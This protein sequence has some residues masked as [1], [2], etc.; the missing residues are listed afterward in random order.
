[1][2]GKN[3]IENQMTNA[4][5]HRYYIA[6]KPW[7]NSI[8]KKLKCS[9]NGTFFLMTRAATAFICFALAS[10]SLAG[11]PVFQ[12]GM[13]SDN[14][15]KHVPLLLPMAEYLADKMQPFGYTSGKPQIF[16]DFDSARQAFQSGDL[17][18]LTCGLYEAAQM[19]SSGDASPLAI[20]WKYGVPE[21]SSL[22]IVN[23]ESEIYELSDLVGKTIG[24]EDPGSTSAYFL[25]YQ[26]LL[27]A[28]LPLKM[29]DVNNQTSNAINYRFTDSEQNSSALLLQN[30]I[31]AIALS[32]YDW[33]KSDHITSGQRSKF[34]IIWISDLYPRA[35]EVVRADMPSEQIIQLEQEL[36]SMHLHSEAQHALDNY[37]ETVRFSYINENHLEQLQELIDLISNLEQT[38]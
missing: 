36:T 3:W 4:N 20:K 6:L 28:K 5:I 23:S 14:P 35:L 16:A 29:S 9:P 17:D 34:R 24:F 26:A 8:A 19:I 31:D 11:Q 27:K 22:I 32:D 2:K 18:I 13:F 21:Y 25:P 15:K 37:H 7:I 12:V 38:E 10:L 1:M 30:K 33:L